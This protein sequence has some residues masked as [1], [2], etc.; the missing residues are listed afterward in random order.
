MIQ[1][2][3]CAVAGIDRRT[4]ATC[5]PTDK[6]WA[7]QLGFSLL[8]SFVVVLGITFHATGYMIENAWLRLLVST[9]VAL[10]VFMFDRALYQSDWFYQGPLQQSDS[11]RESGRRRTG[12]Y[13]FLRITLRI[14]ISLTLA[15]IIAVFLELAIFSDTITEHL[16]RQHVAVNQPVFQKVDRYEAQVAAE[17][18][19]RR[20]ALAALD[21]LYRNDFAVR[22]QTAVLRPPDSTE[23]RSAA[24]ALDQREQELLAELRQ[25]GVQVTRYAEEMNAEELG[26]KVRAT[27]SGRAGAGPRYR[28]AMQQREIYEGIRAERERELAQVRGERERLR[29]ERGRALTALQSQR[30]QE[31]AAAEANRQ[32]IEAQIAAARNELK[33]LEA[34]QLSRVEAFRRQ[35]LASPEF[36]PER[37]DP[38]ARMT[39]YQ[40]LKSDPRHGATI[41][42]F[43]WMTKAL[44]IF[45]EIAP[46]LAKM[47]FAP[48]SVY[49]TRIQAQ[50]ASGREETQAIP[51]GGEIEHLGDVAPPSVPDDVADSASLGD[52]LAGLITAPARP[53][54]GSIIADVAAATGRWASAS[55]ARE[56]VH[57]QKPSPLVFRLDEQAGAARTDS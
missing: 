27:N 21:A 35:A 5:P 49:A 24:A 20:T 30:D 16:K 34:A 47:F 36:Q 38:L 40:E 3:L 43:S 45:L 52:K 2:A 32:A 41:L 44:V 54:L 53:R 11:S 50:I 12:A 4:L 51:A 22:P 42:L 9:V 13:R 29:Q 1:R 26:L 18:E 37:D 57:N 25:I 15:W 17:I 48:P 23:D 31:R 33:T 14:G 7:T 8:L 55:K 10:T 6:L 39:A 28:F 56:R 46:V 19:E